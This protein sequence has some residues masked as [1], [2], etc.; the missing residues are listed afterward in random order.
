MLTKN[1]S[2]ILEK[3]EELEKKIGELYKIFKKQFP[4]CGIWEILILEEQYHALAVVKLRQLV[5]AGK[6]RIDNGKITL[7]AV[8]RLIA[9]VDH[10]AYTAMDEKYTLR[11]AIEIGMKVERT[12][13][14]ANIFKHFTD[15]PESMHLLKVLNGGMDQHGKLLK[16][17]LTKILKSLNSR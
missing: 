8:K 17:E 11:Q 12:I 14:E 9:F 16:D 2:E 15:S 6:S 10:L 3:C 7:E 13:V 5:K 1:Q 4:Q